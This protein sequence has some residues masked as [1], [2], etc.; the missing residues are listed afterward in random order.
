MQ[1]QRC[2][3]CPAHPPQGCA[4]FKR[5]AGRPHPRPTHRCEP[6]SFPLKACRRQPALPRPRSAPRSYHCHC[7]SPL[8]AADDAKERAMG[9]AGPVRNALH[10]FAASHG[11]FAPPP[12]RGQDAASWAW[13]FSARTACGRDLGLSAVTWQSRV[14]SVWKRMASCAPRLVATA[15]TRTLGSE[16][17]GPFFTAKQLFG[18]MAAPSLAVLTA[19]QVHEVWRKVNSCD[20]H[21]VLTAWS[22]CARVAGAQRLLPAHLTPM[23]ASPEARSMVCA[24]VELSPQ[25]PTSPRSSILTSRHL[26]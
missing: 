7:P 3:P 17:L 22:V 14:P 15:V 8:R 10:F 13:S 25:R 24:G 21:P 11:K 23:S 4:A 16:R 1:P 5:P 12:N 2:Q 6:T 20:A 19:G 26:R 9:D 18:F